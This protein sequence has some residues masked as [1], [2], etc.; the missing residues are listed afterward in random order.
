MNMP[1]ITGEQLADEILKIRFDIPVMLCT[2]FSEKMSEEKANSLGIKGFLM[3]P[4]MMKDFSN[5]I[6]KVLDDT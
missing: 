3:K 2:G 1:Y 6:R 4:V 5:M